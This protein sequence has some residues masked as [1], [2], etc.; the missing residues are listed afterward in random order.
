MPG[1]RWLMASGASDGVKFWDIDSLRSSI[2][3]E[4]TRLST[5]HLGIGAMNGVPRNTIIR[6]RPEE[7]L[8]GSLS[9]VSARR[10][11]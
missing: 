11:K 1:G 6:V 5:T 8:R 9:G 2:S 4:G 7:I 3:Y 10:K